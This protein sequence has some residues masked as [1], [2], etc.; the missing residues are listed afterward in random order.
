MLLFVDV[1]VGAVVHAV[2]AVLGTTNRTLAVVQRIVVLATLAC[3]ETLL[4]GEKVQAQVEARR[5]EVKTREFCLLRPRPLCDA[6]VKR[7][8]LQA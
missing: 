6:K 7:R 3:H 1:L 8:E 2:C 4:V 5:V